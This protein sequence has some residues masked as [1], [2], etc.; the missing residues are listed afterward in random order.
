MNNQELL[1]GY[2]EWAIIIVLTIGL[3]AYFSKKYSNFWKLFSFVLIPV[4]LIIAIVK[5]IEY[6]IYDNTSYLLLSIKGFFVLLSETLPM[7]LLFGGIT[8]GIKYWKLRK[9]LKA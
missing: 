4:W 6:I 7:L 1:R 9:R 5:G 3:F 8:F 2:A